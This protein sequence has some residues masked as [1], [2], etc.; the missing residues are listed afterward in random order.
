MK[1]I[2]FDL[3][4]TLILD[5]AVSLDAYRTAAQLGAGAGADPVRLTADAQAAASTLWAEGPY[6]EYCLRIGHSPSEGLWARYDSGAHPA[7]AGLR[8]WALGYRQ[9]VWQRALAL[10]GITAATDLPAQMADTYFRTR[11]RYPLYPEV[12][13]LIDRLLQQGYL[14]GIVTNGVPD[15]QREKLAGCPVAARFHASIV[16]GEIDCGK[17]DPGIFRHICREL[18]VAP[19]ECVMVGDN[20]G[21]DVAGAMAAGMPSVWVQRNGRPRDP[22]YPGDLACT[23]LS[24]MASWLIR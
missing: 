2:L 12:E 21:R 8:D 11:R 24:A 19:A 16:S 22:R 23:D 18:N 1:A 15:L 10:Q 13:G 17:P 3:D 7:I 9:A 14:L 6:Y 5:E 20:P 4:E